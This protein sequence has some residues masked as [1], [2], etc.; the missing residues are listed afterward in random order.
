MPKAKGA[1]GGGGASFLSLFRCKKIRWSQPSAGEAKNMRVE[2]V[3]VI[4]FLI[5][6]STFHFISKKH[7]HTVDSGLI[8]WVLRFGMG[9]VIA[10]LKLTRE[11][12]CWLKNR[13]LS[14]LFLSLF[15][16]GL[17]NGKGGSELWEAFGRVRG[18]NIGSVVVERSNLKGGARNGGAERRQSTTCK[19][20]WNFKL[21][22]C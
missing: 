4:S 10:T 16:V 7:T 21:K 15:L 2:T 6:L 22:S 5:H 20:I 8:F 17:S 18:I 13:T 19:R 1:G 11:I 14:F 3:R 9:G 12:T